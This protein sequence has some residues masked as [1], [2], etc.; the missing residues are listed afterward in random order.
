[1]Q[2]EPP[3]VDFLGSDSQIRP[4]DI[5]HVSPSLPSPDAPPVPLKLC[6]TCR[7]MRPRSEFRRRTPKGDLHCQCK[8]CHR[9]YESRRFRIK[10]DKERQHDF[11]AR[12]TEIV[13][14]EMEQVRGLAVAML[15]EFGGVE[16]TASLLAR[17]YDNAR[18]GSFTR[19]RC[20]AATMKMVEAATPPPPTE[21]ELGAMSDEDLQ[22]RLDAQIQ[23]MI[24]EQPELAVLAAVRLG[25]TVIPPEDESR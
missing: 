23:G 2:L 19:Y 20:L 9:E 3:T 7:Q 8:S 18:K 16:G 10:R 12:L 14:A 17:V 15:N 5:L 11:K 13:N 4:L 22:A 25:W 21:D 1:M 24:E 6:T